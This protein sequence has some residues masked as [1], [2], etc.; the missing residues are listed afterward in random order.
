MLR[1][2]T[3]NAGIMFINVGTTI[4][5]YIMSGLCNSLIIILGICS[6]INIINAIMTTLLECL[7]V[8]KS[9]K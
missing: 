4:P 9:I 1:I 3:I 5:L 8:K 2:K 6:K 7:F